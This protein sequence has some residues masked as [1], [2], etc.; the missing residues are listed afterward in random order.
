LIAAITFCQRVGHS[1]LF[2]QKRE[3]RSMPA[4]FQ[5]KINS[6]DFNADDTHAL[7]LMLD[8]YDI[9]SSLK[10]HLAALELA[11]SRNISISPTELQVEID[12]FRQDA[13]LTRAEDFLNWCKTS[14]I[15]DYAVRMYCEIHL[16]RR[17]LVEQIPQ[18][19]V[20][21]MFANIASDETLYYLYNVTF[22][23]LPSAED[24]ASSIRLGETSLSDVVQK[25][26]D[27]EAKATGGFVGEIPCGDLPEKYQDS[28]VSVDAGTLVGPIQDGDIWIL[29]FVSDK[30]APAFEDFEEAL[31]ETLIDDE[32]EHFSDRMVLTNNDD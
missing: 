2:D 10:L 28:L 27:R 18:S 25:Y 8:G 32:L 31:R 19:D 14:K 4:S 22:D 5:F 16:S 15:T 6:H 21:E 23:D 12:E 26:G 1:E 29:L 20:Q 11:K 24:A 17:K 7:S 3:N 9:R 30:I 13:G